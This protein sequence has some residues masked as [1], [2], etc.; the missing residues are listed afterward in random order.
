VSGFPGAWYAAFFDGERKR[1]WWRLCRPGFRHVLAFGY[2]AQADAWLIYD[3]TLL[4]TYVCAIRPEVFDAW[5]QGL[6]TH[7]TIVR[8]DHPVD[9]PPVDTPATPRRHPVDPRHHAAALHA[10]PRWRHHPAS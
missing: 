6:P 5:L 3:V 2:S 4:R 7:R 9:A 10:A 8:L 1:W